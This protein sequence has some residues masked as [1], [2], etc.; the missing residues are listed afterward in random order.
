MQFDT[1]GTIVV[2]VQFFF[3]ATGA[4]YFPGGTAFCNNLDFNEHQL[5]SLG[6]GIPWYT[7]Q[8]YYKGGLPAY[9][10]GNGGFCGDPAWW[11]DGVPVGT[12]PLTYVD[13]VPP[14]CPQQPCQPW[15]TFGPPPR[16]FKRMLTG[17]TWTPSLNV[18]GQYN[19]RNPALT[20]DHVECT[21]ISVPSCLG[22]STTVVQIQALVGAFVQTLPCTIVSYDASTF[23]GTWQCVTNPYRYSNE[24]FTFRNP[25]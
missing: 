25:T 12:P 24:F 8:T 18:P 2:P 3:A 16:T 1:D 23:T 5:P 15:H 21:R 22:F 10:R 20:T 4:G 7:S 19:A 6:L 13:G 11:T 14:C 9:L 17:A